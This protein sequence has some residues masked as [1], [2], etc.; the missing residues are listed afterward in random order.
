MAINE[1]F[2]KINA[3]VLTQTLQGATIGRTEQFLAKLKTLP[4]DSQYLDPTS[5]LVALLREQR[6]FLDDVL[7]GHEYLINPQNNT[8][9]GIEQGYVWLTSK[10]MEPTL[11]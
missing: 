11:K 1:K 4:W 9:A 5:E 2:R 10:G 3:Q 7:N 8:A 6:A